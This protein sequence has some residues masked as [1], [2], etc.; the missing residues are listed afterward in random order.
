MKLYRHGDVL[1][2]EVNI[3]PTKGKKRRNNVLAHGEVTGHC[4]QIIDGA[5]AM[6]DFDDKV[7]LEVQDKLATLSHEEHHALKL[8]KG[9]YEI[10]IQRE[11]DDEK[12]WRNVL[13]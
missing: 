8:P 1:I 9:N 13:D 3:N 10:I 4:H 7:Y 2:K 6:W 5:A 11:Y 12:E